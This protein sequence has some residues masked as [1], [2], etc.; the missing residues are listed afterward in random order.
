MREHP[1][2]SV[3]TFV[4]GSLAAATRSVPVLLLAAI[5]AWPA[6]ALAQGSNAASRFQQYE[7]PQAFVP[8]FVPLGVKGGGRVKVVV[9]MAADSVAAARARFPDRAL[10][11]DEKRAVEDQAAAEQRGIEPEISG[12]GG[13]VLKRFRHALNGIKVEIDRNQVAALAALP[14]VV[15]VLPV[16]KHRPNNSVGVP[17][18]GAPVVWQGAPGFRGEGIKIAII[19]TG[20]DYTH[21]NFGGPG[22]V[23]AFQAAAAASTQ[24]P[25]PALFGPN[26]AKVKGGTDLVGDDY[27]A[28]ADPG[29]PALVPHPD[30]NPLD[31]NG[32]GSHVAGT[33]AGFGVGASGATYAGPYDSAAF[34]QGFKIGP[35][36]APKAD[37]YSVRV[38]GC[39][40]STDVV[41][42][43]IDWAVQND[44][45]VINMSLGADFVAANSADALAAQN[46]AKAGVLVVAAAGNA[47]P[48]PYIT[49]SPASGNGVISVAAV[50][51]SA[52]FPAAVMALAGGK[53]ITAIDANGAPLPG[54]T[55]PVFVLRN[56]AGTVSL[57]CNEAEYVDASIAGKLV[58]TLRGVCA[59]VDR[60]VFGQRHGAA[61]VVMINTGPGY[62]PFEGDIP[63]VAI[64][65]LGVLASDA[66]TL[67]PSATAALASGTLANPGFRAVADFSSGGP[68]FGDSHL[69][70]NVAAPG[71]SILSTFSGSGNQGERLSGTSMASPHVAGVAALVRQANPSWDQRALSAAVVQT[72]DPGQLNNF[73]S[74]LDGSGLVQPIR[75]TRTQA[76][77]FA[78][79]GDRDRGDR[80]RG[81]REGGD[82]LSFGFEEL[83]HDFNSSLELKVSN[84]GRTPIAFR[85][86]ATPGGG[87]PHT[88]SFNRSTILVGPK[89]D[90]SLDVKLRVPAA[91]VG[92]ASA[93]RE[94]AGF[95]I[96]TPTDASMNGGV[97]LRVPYYLVPR[98]RSDVSSAFVGKPAGPSRPSSN[99]KLTNFGGAIAGNA[100]FYA[101]G[102]KGT[103]Q[104]VEF[105]DV[106]AVGVQS[107]LTSATNGVLVFAVNTFERFS[108]AA[109][110]EFDIL[111]DVNGDGVPDFDLVGIDLGAITAG[112]FN[113]QLASALIHLKTGAVRIRFLADAPTDGSTVLLP[114]LASDL[115]ITP[116]NPR[117]TYSAQVFNLLDGSAAEVPGAASF[118]AFTPA[119]SNAMFVPVA[120]KATAS[121][122]VTVDPV[123]W[124]KTPALGLMVVTGDNRAGA[125]QARLIEA[126]R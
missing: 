73:A 109:A 104:G 40:G 117:L 11:S 66:P 125:P 85:V 106:R 33:A 95:V 13:R 99:V 15:A 96:L 56:F 55:L 58:V 93:Y 92:N 120:P 101:W 61:A 45:D 87:A 9:V 89:D 7:S 20:I 8:A 98:V 112:I 78:G 53:S 41:T 70:P 86:T 26:A 91:S 52:S 12:R 44:M 27:D 2:Q 24:P 16:L 54:G 103:R 19:D 17:F 107:I 50:D 121:V 90:E 29:S 43:A 69:K 68:R 21:A 105:F 6:A 36:V 46:A 71:V 48:A 31:C 42:E 35:G 83:L 115:G 75:A 126:G 81:D 124:A 25:N 82:S 1:R 118:N 64:P 123:E 65:F 94:V 63:G 3:D 34:Q 77:A 10:T 22:T 37:I 38:F 122:P 47:G 4:T 62:P 114:V 39:N 28:S 14:G 84:L 32:H 100:D 23:A 67:T 102:L 30:P 49:G 57:G 5:F 116:A 76:V 80:D 97:S 111:I 59:R 74:R 110:G 119:I 72:A 88:V 18:V 51:S 108:N 113:G 60:A 79:G